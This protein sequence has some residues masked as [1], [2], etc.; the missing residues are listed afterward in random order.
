MTRTVP[1]AIG[2]LETVVVMAACVLAAA[3]ARTAAWRICG[4][5]MLSPFEEAM[6]DGTRN[7]SGDRDHLPVLDRVRASRRSARSVTFAGR[8]G[9]AMAGDS[10]GIALTCASA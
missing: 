6:R 7:R 3:N 9:T 8:R 1:L 2:T 5:R 4:M 10:S